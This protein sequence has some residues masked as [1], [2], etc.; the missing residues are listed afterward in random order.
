M[1]PRIPQTGRAARGAEAFRCEIK[2]GGDRKK[3]VAAEPQ[4]QV[5]TARELL[6]PRKKLRTI[7]VDGTI[8]R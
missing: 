2:E 1:N 5:P 4:G 6:T 7:I 3:K 8:S